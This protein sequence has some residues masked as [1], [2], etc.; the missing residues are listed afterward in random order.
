MNVYDLAREGVN[1]AGS[2]YLYAVGSSTTNKGTMMGL[3]SLPALIR[4][5]GL[6]AALSYC[7]QFGPLDPMSLVKKHLEALLG[8]GSVDLA[9]MSGSEVRYLTIEATKFLRQL[10]WAA[11]SMAREPERAV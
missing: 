7:T 4:A 6:A 2:A 11:E 1:V 9:E 8:V 10:Q 3:R 5:S